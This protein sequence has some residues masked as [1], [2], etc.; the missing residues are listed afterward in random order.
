MK[1]TTPDE[2]VYYKRAYATAI[3]QFDKYFVFIERAVSK[4]KPGARLGM[5]VPNKWITIESGEKL[6][7]LLAQ[8][9]LVA[10]VVDF[11]NELLFEG[12]STYVCLLVLAKDGGAQFAYRHIN[13][14]ADFLQ[15]P[16][17]PGFIL[18]ITVLTTAGS[19]AWVLPSSAPEAALLGKLTANSVPL[20]QLAEVKV[21][22]QTSAN[23]V[24]LI[25]HFTDHGHL[26]EFDK[27]GT[28]WRIEK[29]ITRPHINDS[30]RVVSYQP[31]DADARLIFPYET[32]PGGTPAAIDPSVMASKYPL[33]LAYLTAYQSRLLRRDVTPPPKPG[34]FYAYGRHQSLEAVFSAPKIVY[35]VNQRGSKYAIDTVGVSYASGGT[36]GEVAIVNPKEGYALE[37]FLGLLNQKAIE[38]FVRKRG[39]SFRGGYFAR[40]KPIVEDVPVPHLEIAGNP[41]HRIAHDTIVDDVQGLIRVQQALRTASGRQQGVLARQRAALE[42]A[43]AGKFDALWGFAGDVDTLSLPGDNSVTA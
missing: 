40:G 35:S 34:V 32:L 14:Y 36:A 5:V 7:G 31:I 13:R 22:I 17:E 18:P 2:M 26:I 38:F 6:R 20:S 11:G 3:R 43:L 39:S 21:G 25:P 30:G 9:S 41:A 1:G 19:K 10:E 12:K 27:G 37:F 4:M 42:Q 24:F 8:G 28:P 23:D 16:R 33:A 15:D 29:A